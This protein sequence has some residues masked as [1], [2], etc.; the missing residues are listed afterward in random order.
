[1]R[2]IVRPLAILCLLLA[3]FVPWA[4]LLFPAPAAAPAAPGSAFVLRPGVVINSDGTILYMMSPG[5]GTRAV[6]VLS[7]RSIWYTEEAAKPL[8]VS[9]GLLVALKN[10]PKVEPE[11]PA[12]QY[13]D[14]MFLNARDGQKQRTVQVPLPGQDWSAID[15]GPGLA[16]HVAASV[17]QASVALSWF[18]EGNK[19]TGVAPPR[20]ATV[21]GRSAAATLSKTNGGKVRI[22]I[23]TGLVETEPVDTATAE[24]LTRLDTVKESQLAKVSS[25]RQGPYLS[26]DGRHVLASQLVGDDRDLKTKYLWTISAADGTR[27]GE[28]YSP[29]PRAPF[30]VS[31]T[32]LIFESRPYAILVNGKMTREPLTLRVVDI[33]SGTATWS[34]PLRD[35]TFYGPFPEFY[36]EDPV[37]DTHESMPVRKVAAEPF[38]GTWQ[39]IGPAPKRSGTNQ[40]NPPPTNEVS[41]CIHAIAVHPTN[42]DILY[43]GAVNGGIWKATNATNARPDWVQLTDPQ[44]SIS[45]GAMDLDPMDPSGQTLVAGIGRFSSFGRRGG[46]RTGLLRTIDGGTSWTPLDGGVLSGKNISGIA[47]AGPR[48]VVSVNAADASGVQQLGIFRSTDVGATFTQISSGNGSATGL[49]FGI[50]YDVIRDPT[51]PDRLF[52]GVVGATASGG[53]NG[54]YRSDDGGATWAKVSN[55]AI[56]SLINNNTSNIEFAVAANNVVYTLLVNSGRLAGIFQSLDAGASWTSMDVPNANPNGQGS[57]HLSEAV[58]PNDPNIVYVGGDTANFRCNATRPSG[59]QCTTLQG[60]GTLRNTSPHVDTREMVFDAAGRLLMVNDGGIHLRTSPQNNQGDWFSMSNNIQVF[61]GHSMAF[62]TNAGVAMAGFQDNGVARALAPDQAVWVTVNGGD[63]GDVAVDATST[64][65]LS[66]RYS[67]SQNLG[68][69]RRQVYN[70]NNVL[71][72]QV[73]P[74]R[75]LVGGG[76]APTYQFVTPIRVNNVDGRRLLIGGSNALYESFDQGETIRQLTPAFSVNSNGHPLAYGA[77]GNPDVIYVGSGST[78]RVRTEA[79][80]APLVQSASYPGT[81]TGRAVIDMVIDQNDPNTLFVVDSTNVYLTNNAGGSWTNI[82]G[83]LLELV[84]GPLRSVAH[85]RNAT[86][87]AVVVGANYGVFAALANSGFSVWSPIGSGFPSALAYDLEYVP[88]RDLLVAGTLGRGTWLLPQPSFTTTLFASNFDANESG[89]TFVKDAFGTNQPNY[90]TGG[91]SGGGLRVV[92]GGVNNE[93]VLGMSG[94]WRRAFDLSSWQFVTVS[95]DFNLTQNP[96]YEND[97]SSDMLSQI[98]NQPAVVQAHI[99]GDGNGGKPQSTGQV[100]RV[101]NL[102]C[103]PP[104]IHSVTLGVRSTKKTLDNE[105]TTLLLDNVAVKSSGPCQQERPLHL[106]GNADLRKAK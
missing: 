35:T 79:P 92:V 87:E 53:Q 101:L 86:G 46:P 62:D 20:A 10:T 72:S 106:G 28:I 59:S 44:A 2:I 21:A 81:G 41:G 22:N 84:P 71:Q 16:L 100:S 76:A 29:F 67:S 95:F 74:A 90:A 102:G 19:L 49:P 37:Q 17:E 24:R 9:G 34:F 15:D 33:S 70:A 40:T 47:L 88:A 65:G 94:G 78:I 103:L 96:D 12:P 13:L 6:D 11:N 73:F 99:V 3:S 18:V 105:S 1:M 54:V 57:I 61:E 77:A 63:G 36:K 58:D 27:I 14:V 5:G 25:V 83:N 68:S 56:D 52:T 85:I 23:E 31:G 98:D 39:A 51:N 55:S 97:E 32:K 43:I 64:P 26:A 80:P 30:F 42:P 93:D 91:F 48:I 69:F 66:S 82:T 7:G 38:G 104:G 75:T 50:N 60:S 45:I 4:D 8:T 89:F